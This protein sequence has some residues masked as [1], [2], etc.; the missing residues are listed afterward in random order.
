MKSIKKY[1]Y[2]LI[3]ILFISLCLSYILIIPV[4]EAPDENYHFLYSFYISKYNKLF[5]KYDENISVDQYI[6]ENI[7]AGQDTGLYID[8]KYAVMKNFDKNYHPLSPW[9]DP[10]VYYLISSRLIKPFEVDKVGAEFNY[11]DFNNP[12]RFVNNK[13]LMD[14]NHTIGLV[15]MLRLLQ[16]IFGVGIIIIIFNII[17][18]ISDYK[19]KNQP[20]LLLSS[21]VFIPQFIFLCSYVN[22]DL[23]SILF[24]LL[25]VYFIVLLFKKE[26][27]YWGLLSIIFAIIATLTKDTLFIMVP[28]AIITIFIWSIVKKKKKIIYGFL[29]FI[30]LFISA[31]YFSLNFQK[32]TH[33]RSELNQSWTEGFKNKNNKGFSFDGV[34]DSVATSISYST[35]ADELS[36]ECNAYFNSFNRKEKNVTT[37]L[38]T[39]LKNKENIKSGIDLRAIY[40]S[41]ND[42]LR[43]QFRIGSGENFI[44]VTGDVLPYQDFVEK[45]SKKWLNVSAIYE[46]EKCLKILVNGKELA[47]NDKDIP[48]NLLIG[49]DPILYFGYSSI[50]PGYLDGIIDTVRI[51]D[52]ALTEAQIRENMNK[53]LT[54]NE[55][56]LIGYWN[57]NEGKGSIVHDLTPNQNHGKIQVTTE[58]SF[59]LL[60]RAKGVAKEFFTEPENFF[61]F[62]NEHFIESFKSSVAVFGWMNIYADNHIYYFFL[63]YIIA[64]VFLFFANIKQYRESKRPIIFI[65]ASIISVYAYF[66][67][68]AF[69]TDWA[70]QQ[71]R[72]MFTAVMLTFILAI[73]GYNT[74]KSRYRNIIYYVL[75]SCSLFIIIF[76]LYNYI[77]LQYY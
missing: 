19:F 64:G 29:I 34:D 30:V 45:Y 37:P 20:I 66:L 11:E 35:K 68:Y 27:F 26:K 8:E 3:I 69:Y 25:S 32:I 28:I 21:I 13:I 61:N 33:G 63:A 70:Q 23:L 16:M 47:I 41:K 2:L 77:Y 17:K 4:F 58:K 52:I 5:S 48:E 22:N 6:Q 31:F 71:G 59:P 14:N 72:V 9:S 55:E 43:W 60:N 42:T 49:E 1:I 18:L 24:G 67:L 10:P 76:S 39:N 12:N 54:G 65:I 36:V 51:W 40:I 15:L 46:S 74:I 7:D 75:F 56:G 73:L 50:N 38:I 57:F 44:G 62:D 53:E